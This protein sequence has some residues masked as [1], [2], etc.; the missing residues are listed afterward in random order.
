M[1]WKIDDYMA[2]NGNNQTLKT[3]LME[4]MEKEMEHAAIKRRIGRT[5]KFRKSTDLTVII[6]YNYNMMRSL[7]KVVENGKLKVEMY[8]FNY[9]SFLQVPAKF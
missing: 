7:Q 8:S 9:F 6:A 3:S 4:A 5:I 2:N 1:M